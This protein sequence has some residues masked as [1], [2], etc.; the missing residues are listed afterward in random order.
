ME[1]YLHTPIRLRGKIL[2][3]FN[4]ALLSSEDVYCGT[5]WEQDNELQRGKDLEAD[6]GG[7]FQSIISALI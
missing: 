6:G 5:R 3:V 7:S 2:P 1:L 4:D